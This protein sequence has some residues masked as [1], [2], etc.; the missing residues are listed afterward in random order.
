MLICALTVVEGIEESIGL[1]AGVQARIVKYRQRLL[2]VVGRR[3][4]VWVLGTVVTRRLSVCGLG[5]GGHGCH[6]HTL[7]RRFGRRSRNVIFGRLE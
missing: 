1:D 2:R 6:E 5:G 3:E 7:I 4:R